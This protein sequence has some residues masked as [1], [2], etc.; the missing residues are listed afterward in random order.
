MAGEGDFMSLGLREGRVEF[1]FD[2]G[3]GP[4]II[5]SDPIE[6]GRWHT[7][8]IKRNHKEGVYVCMFIYVRVV[9]MYVCMYVQ[10]LCS[11]CTCMYVTHICFGCF[12]T[13]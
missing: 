8:R 13:S 2:V 9:C 1:R 5:Q 7:V 4:A 6:M 3:S 11:P 10:Y 12:F